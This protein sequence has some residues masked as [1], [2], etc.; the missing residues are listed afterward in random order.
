MFCYLEQS[1]TE[2]IDYDATLDI[3]C[4]K[5]FHGY[6]HEIHAS[7]T[8]FACTPTNDKNYST[9]IGLTVIAVE[10]GFFWK[11]IITGLNLEKFFTISLF[12]TLCCFAQTP[13]PQRQRI[14]VYW[15]P[16]HFR[17]FGRSDLM[18]NFVA[19]L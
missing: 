5:S 8:K 13:S 7:N 9:G 11:E 6:S 2:N 15:N 14:L 17:V 16:V 18:G 12:L 19:T 4:W 1:T 3:R 10:Y